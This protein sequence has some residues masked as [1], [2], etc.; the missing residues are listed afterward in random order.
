[1]KGK[2]LSLPQKETHPLV[3]IHA[4]QQSSTQESIADDP[5]A[6]PPRPIVLP[7]HRGY[8]PP[9]SSASQT[10]STPR[11]YRRN[12]DPIPSSLSSAQDHH[13]STSHRKCRTTPPSH[14]SH[15]TRQPRPDLAMLEYFPFYAPAPSK[16]CNARV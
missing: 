7:M 6:G 3:A 14:S 5:R 2:I 16:Y 4:S 9:I 11:Q 10:Q 12:H 8:A 13:R 1:M 15:P